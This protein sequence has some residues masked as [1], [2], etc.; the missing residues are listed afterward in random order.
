MAINNDGFEPNTPLTFEQV[1]A[2]ARKHSDNKNT[3][4]SIPKKQNRENGVMSQEF[5][6]TA[7]K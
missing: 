1:Q 7:I 2:L 6:K 3:P 5:A 4:T